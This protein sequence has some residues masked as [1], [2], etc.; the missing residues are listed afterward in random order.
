MDDWKPI[1]Q[2]DNTIGSPEEFDPAW[3][4]NF[5]WG[6]D[7][8]TNQ[9]HVWRVKGG[10]DG[11]LTMEDQPGS[12]RGQLEIQMGREPSAQSGDILGLA[13]FIPAEKKL[14]GTMVAPPV[15]LIQAYYKAEIPQG[16]FDWFEDNF[17]GSVARK[18]KIASFKQ[19]KLAFEWDDAFAPDPHAGEGKIV[20]WIYG[21]PEGLLLW[22]TGEDQRP[23]HDEAAS[24]TWGRVTVRG[25][26][27]LG[28]AIPEG[29][30][31]EIEVSRIDTPIKVIQEV[32][33]EV[34]KL[35][36][37]SQIYL[38]T[39][40]EDHENLGVEFSTDPSTL[41]DHAASAAWAQDHLGNTARGGLYASVT[42]PKEHVGLVGIDTPD[43]K[44]RALKRLLRPLRKKADADMSGAMIAVFLPK[45]VGEKIKIEGGEPVDMM[46]ITLCYF[47]DKAADRDD[48]DEVEEI[49]AQFAKKFPA[50]SG[51]IGGYGVFSNEEPVLWAAPAIPQLAELRHELTTACNEA[52]FN[53]SDEYGWT[54][55]ITLAYDWDDELP[56]LDSK[57]PVEFKY[58][59]FARG[60]E[61]T[62][63]RFTGTLSKTSDQRDFH[64]WS[65]T[66]ENRD[67]WGSADFENKG[68]WSAIW[69]DGAPMPYGP[70]TWSGW[71]GAHR[72]VS[73]GKEFMSEPEENLRWRGKGWHGLGHPHLEEEFKKRHQQGD[74]ELHTMSGWAV[75]T[76]DGGGYGLYGNQWGNQVGVHDVIHAAQEH[77]GKPVHLTGMQELRT[78]G[79][80]QSYPQGGHYTGL[81]GR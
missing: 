12:H 72:F 76:I 55:H 42:A 17:P 11:R 7:A 2:V 29:D 54:P 75:P 81:T 68:D 66:L 22:Q 10:V 4:Y 16:V 38:P 21:D 74:E 73:D 1:P 67:D 52:G 64:D 6:F 58:L 41:V 39:V 51:E 34:A 49:V 9:T 77:L 46:H 71:K 36:P 78:P 3:P 56:K 40:Q 69:K 60:N 18:A 28:Y 5:K 24:D 20:K 44:F 65:G 35:Y 59:R 70:Q 45:K 53:V 19:P 62:D 23:T 61:G 57:I 80:Y 50:L 47:T 32:K 8:Q 79:L 27:Y 48:W 31:V 25:K 14:D 37:D 26:D 30:A 63:H 15:V 33:A 43:S 13:Q